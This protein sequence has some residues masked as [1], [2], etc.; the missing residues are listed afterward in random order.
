MN[1]SKNKKGANEKHFQPAAF[2]DLDG[3]LLSANSGKLWLQ[4]ERRMGRLDNRQTLLGIWYLALY[5]AGII[6]MEKVTVEALKTVKGEKE[7]TLRRW[8]HAWFQETVVPHVA[9]ASD[10]ALAFHRSQ[11]HPLVL[12]TSSSRYESE[13]AVEH[14]NLDH[15]LCMGYEVSHGRFTGEVRKPLCFG[16]GKVIHAEKF[17]LDHGVSLEK[18]F[19]YSDSVTDL[20]MLR[21][22]GRPVAVNPD[23]RLSRYASKLGWPIMDWSTPS[24]FIIPK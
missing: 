5:K 19:F 9:P 13:A 6:D 7:E 20:P 2:F 10:N 16:Q 14:F 24:G 11:G 15:F 12:L 21:R 8:T 4:R 22:V 18:S 23:F 3:T 17:A 1:T